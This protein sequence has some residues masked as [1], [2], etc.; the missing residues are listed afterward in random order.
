MLGELPDKLRKAAGILERERNT[1]RAVAVGL[2]HRRRALA[3]ELC[4][5][6]AGALM[7]I[8]GVP[9]FAA[10]SGACEHQR[11]HAARMI[12]R[13]LQGGVAAH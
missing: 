2:R 11:A 7:E 5:D 1:G 13:N 4:R 8:L 9:A 10:G 3:F 12:E 6:V